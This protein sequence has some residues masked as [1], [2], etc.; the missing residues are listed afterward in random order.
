MAEP[1]TDVRRR[2]IYGGNVQGVGFRYTARE[3]SR[4]FRVTG[5]VRN[6]ADGSVELE[7]EGPAGEVERFLDAI[8]ERLRGNIQRQQVTAQPPRGDTDQFEITY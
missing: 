7:A 5:W 3:L 8:A 2:V 4:Q 1:H 6:L